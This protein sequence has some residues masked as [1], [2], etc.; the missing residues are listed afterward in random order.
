MI[1]RGW[2]AAGGRKEQTG[3]EERV[4]VQG[5]LR[6]CEESGREQR[7]LGTTNRSEGKRSLPGWPRAPECAAKRLHAELSHRPLGP[8]SP[9]LVWPGTVSSGYSTTMRG[10]LFPGPWSPSAAES[11]ATPALHPTSSPRYFSQP[12]GGEAMRPLFIVWLYKVHLTSHF[13]MSGSR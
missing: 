7:P 13:R 2:G 10:P 9:P 8:L 5:T 3:R 6:N 12:Q 1:G 4:L 11:P